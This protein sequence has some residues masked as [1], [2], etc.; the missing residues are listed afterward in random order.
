[1]N[2][3]D[4]TPNVFARGLG[5]NSVKT[6]GLVCPDVSDRYTANAIAYLEKI[7]ASMDMTQF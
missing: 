7:Y 2:E 3:Y 4:Y 5:L 6:V 1:M